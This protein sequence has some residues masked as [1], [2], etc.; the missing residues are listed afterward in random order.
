MVLQKGH[1][2]FLFVWLTLSAITF[3]MIGCHGP[4][5]DETATILTP[6]VTEPTFQPTSTAE[7]LST[8]EEH[9]PTGFPLQSFQSFLP[10]G[11]DGNIAAMEVITDTGKTIYYELTYWSDGL[12]VQGLLGYP[13]GEGFYPAVVIN[14]SGNRET[15]ALGGWELIPFVESGYV[16]IGSQYRGNVGGEGVEEFGGADVQDVLNLVLLLKS[17]TMVDPERIVMM[18]WSRGGMQTLIALKLDAQDGNQ[19]IRA[20]AIVSSVIDLFMWADER[21]DALEGVLIPLIGASPTER[22]DLYEARSATYW[23]GLIHTPLLIVHGEADERVSVEQARKLAQALQE[24]DRTVELV[25]YPGEDHVLSNHRKGFP[26]TMS[27]FQQYLQNPGED[28]ALDTHAE[29]IKI[30]SSWFLVNHP[31]P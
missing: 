8:P 10:T 11:A 2:N 3:F 14:R 15:G 25:I 26:D 6:Q 27:W 21:P 24:A 16:A 19:D 31:P 29:A 22:P 13:K 9:T 28:L 5:P 1:R 23:P 17:L 20:A 30:V 4:Q 7:N 18:G 12:R